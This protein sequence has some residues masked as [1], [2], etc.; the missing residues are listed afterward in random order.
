MNTTIWSG[1]ELQGTLVVSPRKVRL[2]REEAIVLRT[3]MELRIAHG[4]SWKRYAVP[5]RLQRATGCA[6]LN[7]VRILI[8]KLRAA[9]GEK[10]IETK[11]NLGYV[12]MPANEKHGTTVSPIDALVN[13]LERILAEARRLQQSVREGLYHEQ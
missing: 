3:L 11:R 7:A 6:S 2:T 5:E 13:D 8:L 1:W 9:L 10:A 4:T 12:L